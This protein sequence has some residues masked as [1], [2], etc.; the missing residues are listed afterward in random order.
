[1]SM[2]WQGLRKAKIPVDITVRANDYKNQKKLAL[3][4]LAHFIVKI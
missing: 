1:M 4:T 3:Y 2:N